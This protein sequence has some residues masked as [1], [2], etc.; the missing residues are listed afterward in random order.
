M[1]LWVRTRAESVTLAAPDPRAAAEAVA[2]P[3]VRAT[4]LIVKLRDAPALSVPTAQQMRTPERLP[5]EET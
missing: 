2:L 5:E 4:V 3:A 1:K